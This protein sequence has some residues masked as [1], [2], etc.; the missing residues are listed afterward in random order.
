[1]CLGVSLFPA[2]VKVGGRGRVWSSLWWGRCAMWRTGV[3]DRVEIVV[4]WGAGSVGGRC[5]SQHEPY[6]EMGR[7][8][9]LAGLTSPHFPQRHIP[10]QGKDKGSDKLRARPPPQAHTLPRARWPIRSSY[11]GAGLAWSSCAGGERKEPRLPSAAPW[12]YDISL[13]ML[14]QSGELGREMGCHTEQLN[15]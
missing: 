9:S 15:R 7:M 3:V 8:F 1:M 14:S 13:P 12:T 4:F 10:S 6:G 5:D 2:A 11:A